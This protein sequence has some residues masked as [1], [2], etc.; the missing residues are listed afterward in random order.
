[1]EIAI[2]IKEICILHDFFLLTLTDRSFSSNE[3]KLV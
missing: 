2:I 3:E 1:M